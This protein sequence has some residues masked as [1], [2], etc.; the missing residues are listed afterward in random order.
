MGTMDVSSVLPQFRKTTV[1][2]M[3]R[4]SETVQGVGLIAIA[5]FLILYD[6][7]TG[8]PPL[9]KIAADVLVGL[10]GIVLL[11]YALKTGSHKKGKS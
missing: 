2:R 5:I 7:W 9:W 4:I 1:I 11:L 3:V 8:G 6:L 10:F